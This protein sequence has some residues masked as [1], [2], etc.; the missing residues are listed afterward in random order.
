MNTMTGTDLLITAVE[1]GI[2]HWARV[3]EY[4]HTGPHRFA[5]VTDTT[6]GGTYTITPGDM[7]AACQ[8]VLKLYPN[9]VAARD[10]R[11]DHVDADDADLIFQVACFGRAVYG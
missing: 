8:K 6:D 10:I 1:G 4:H 9:S 3:R 2:N 5:T 7:R 11:E